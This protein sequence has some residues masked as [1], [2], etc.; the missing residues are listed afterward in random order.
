MAWLF[1]IRGSDISFNPVAF[2]AA[3]LTLEDAF[4][5]IDSHKIGDDVK[6]ASLCI[7][8]VFL[9]AHIL[10]IRVL[11]PPQILIWHY[12]IMCS[13]KNVLGYVSFLDIHVHQI[14]K[15]LCTSRQCETCGRS[16]QF[17]ESHRTRDLNLRRTLIH[18]IGRTLNVKR[19]T[20]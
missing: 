19:P 6:Q 15:I 11:F 8:G 1:N 2:S 12:I 4:L 9:R 3:L 13:M 7:P 17:G 5:F 18:C 14:S 16:S 10:R 20:D